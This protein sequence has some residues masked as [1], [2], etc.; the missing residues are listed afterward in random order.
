MILDQ[1]GIPRFYEGAISFE[2]DH[3]L[4]EMFGGKTN[5]EN[6]VLSCRSCNR[7][8]SRLSEDELKGLEELKSKF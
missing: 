7:S 1:W 3:K 4:P 5:L 6:I 2:F 8:R